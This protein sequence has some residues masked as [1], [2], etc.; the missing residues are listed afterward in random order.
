MLS[1]ISKCFSIIFIWLCCLIFYAR[2]DQI[3]ANAPT[4]DGYVYVDGT[5]A[6]VVG[7]WVKWQDKNQSIRY[8]KTDDTGHYQFR[9]W[10]NDDV[11]EDESERRIDTD[12][13][14]Q[15]DAYQGH[16]TQPSDHAFGCGEGPHIFSVIKPHNALG[17]FGVNMTSTM[18]EDNFSN[19]I[20]RHTLPNFYW[21]P[22]KPVE[23]ISI[24]GCVKDI[25]RYAIAN[26]PVNVFKTDG[27]FVSAT[28]DINGCY[29]ASNYVQEGHYYAV[30]IDPAT[31]PPAFMSDIDAVG[32]DFNN[33]NSGTIG[34]TFNH[35][36]NP[37]QDTAVGAESY[38]CQQ[39]KS[40]NDCAGPA[41]DTQLA[42]RCNFVL[43]PQGCQMS[44]TTIKRVEQRVIC[45]QATQTP[46][47]PNN[48]CYQNTTHNSCNPVSPVTS[49]T[50][51]QINWIGYETN[52]VI[53]MLGPNG[54]PLPATPDSITA[55][56]AAGAVYDPNTQRFT[57]DV[58]QQIHNQLEIV[59]VQQCPDPTP[60]PTIAVFITPEPKL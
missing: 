48:A 50:E 43:K 40:T 3:L 33:Y 19:T 58:C 16:S 39:A 15:N 29:L 1:K 20:R 14:G 6:P 9:S 49:T 46:Q 32:S 8:A 56:S 10:Q 28:T 52:T 30:R 21:Y 57:W 2:H 5:G 26:L 44:D 12:L 54:Q 13:D 59:Y 36:L 22:E 7:V 34:W 35:C 55:A 47:Q 31:I 42:N 41:G 60:T 38:E 17:N 37:K 51:Y 4:V 23:F 11:R 27:S 25:N 18:L 53:S 24:G 45:T